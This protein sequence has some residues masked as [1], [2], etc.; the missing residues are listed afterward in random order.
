M[1]DDTKLQ[2]LFHLLR[3]CGAAMIVAAGGTFLVQSWDQT[4]DVLRY[5]A[6]LGMTGLLPAVAYLCGVRFRE[7]RSARVL[8]A[9]FLAMVPIH[10]G[11]LG[12][13]VLSQFGSE[14]LALG[15]VAQWVAPSKIGALALVAGAAAV[16]VPLT[17]AAFR[18]LARPHARLLT[19]ASVG[20]HAILLVPDRSVE[21][22]TLAMIPILAIAGWCAWRV[23]PETRESKLALGFLF[24]P[25]VVM[26][27]RQVLFYD[28]S[29]AFWSSILAACAVGLYLMGRGSGDTT[30]E[31]VAVVPAMLAT[32]AFLIDFAPVQH[33]SISSMWLTYGWT[34]G[35]ACLAFAWRSRR[36]TA[37]FISAAVV[38]N[39]FT[40]GTTL[41]GSP[42]PLG[43][44][45]A[46]AIGIGLSS[47]GFIRGRQVALYSGIALG[48]LGFIVEVSHAIETFEPS[49]WFALGAGGASLVALT[50]WLERRARVV[51]LA[52]TSA[53][54][55]EPAPAAVS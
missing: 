32:A 28:V 12:G 49:G 17:W 20:T 48:G 36:S 7:G 35:L 54:V 40:A 43:A 2:Q 18:V 16:L 39:A 23:R 11:V 21:A 5:L 34:T 8:V 52:D 53:N 27:A 19:V 26:A 42:G 3:L 33:L 10:A 25:A 46:I 45:Q 13:F 9:T 44:L 6:L 29:G 24:A 51:R 4:G 31:R 47:Y 38:L 30:V 55:S 15:S 50:A 37:F 1:N 41:V 14:T 22:A